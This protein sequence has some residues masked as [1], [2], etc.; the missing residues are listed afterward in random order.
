LTAQPVKEL[1]EFR[2]QADGD[3]VVHV[4]SVL[5][6]DSVRNVS[7]VVAKLMRRASMRDI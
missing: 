3:G 5:H 7:A 4:S 1:P 2:V 6:K